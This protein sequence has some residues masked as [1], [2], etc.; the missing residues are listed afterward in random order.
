MI[1][2]LPKSIRKYIAKEKNRLRRDGLAK[3][4]VAQKIKEWLKMRTEKPAPKPTKKEKQEKP[5]KIKEAKS[6]KPLK[7]EQ[8]QEKVAP[9]KNK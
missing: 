4:E 6:K 5:K 8:K 7:V 9:V 3:E 2:K 1:K